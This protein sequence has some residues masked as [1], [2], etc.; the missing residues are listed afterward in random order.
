MDERQNDRNPGLPDYDD[1]V[2]RRREAARQK[3][4]EE[5]MRALRIQR[6]VFLG[7]AALLLI[8]EQRQ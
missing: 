6:A 2:M 4:R 5:R 8:V 3:R 1:E 7:A